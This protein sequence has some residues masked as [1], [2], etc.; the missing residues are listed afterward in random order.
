MQDFGIIKNVANLSSLEYFIRF[1]TCCN[2]TIK[3][4]RFLV[5][6]KVRLT[7]I[8][9][10]ERMLERLTLEYYDG[11]VLL[12][13]GKSMCFVKD[14]VLGNLQLLHLLIL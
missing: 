9:L 6:C 5:T 4:E 13:T 3:K 7:F 1:W 8:K 2:N 11:P 12:N 14:W 10:Q